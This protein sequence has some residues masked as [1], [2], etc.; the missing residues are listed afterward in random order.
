M[1]IRFAIAIVIAVKD[2]FDR[3]KRIADPLAVSIPFPLA[4]EIRSETPTF[5]RAGNSA[6][7]HLR[8]TKTAPFWW[9][10]YLPY[11]SNK[12]VLAGIVAGVVA[13]GHVAL[14]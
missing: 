5:F 12:L 7:D 9:V 10:V 14:A 4:C 3:D 2:I 13:E 6:L 8:M 11:N 1:R